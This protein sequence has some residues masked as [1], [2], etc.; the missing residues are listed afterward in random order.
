MYTKNIFLTAVLAFN[1]TAISQA[2]EYTADVLASDT[3]TTPQTQECCSELFALSYK[4]TPTTMTEQNVRLFETMEALIQD[5]HNDNPNFYQQLIHFLIDLHATVSSGA[6]LI[7]SATTETLSIT[8]TAEQ[9]LEEYLHSNQDVAKN[10]NTQPEDAL[11]FK[12]VIINSDLENT[13]DWENAKQILTNIQQT[14]QADNNTS[15]EELTQTLQSIFTIKETF[16]RT[17]VLSASYNKT[18]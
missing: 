16:H 9:A 18:N 7:S 12:V 8:S 17:M 6:Q 2:A 3:A 10:E 4:V 11:E 14:L 15:P 1:I 5:A 13:Q